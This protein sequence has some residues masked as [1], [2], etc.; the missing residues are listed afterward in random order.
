MTRLATTLLFAAALNACTGADSEALRGEL[1]W[2]HEVR[3]FCP[4]GSDDCYWIVPAT[5]D[6]RERF[7]ELGSADEPYTPVC[8]VLSGTLDAES[9]RDGFAADYE[10]LF[11]ATAVSTCED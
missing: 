7:R 10:G 11:K 3:S 9:P 5:D 4:A 6:L 8:V 1:T 2:G